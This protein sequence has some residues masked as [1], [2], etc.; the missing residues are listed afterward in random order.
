MWSDIL[1][2]RGYR[3]P[4]Q[5]RLFIQLV[6]NLFKERNIPLVKHM[7]MEFAL[8]LARAI[9]G[10]DLILKRDSFLL[11]VMS[12]PYPNYSPR[13]GSYKEQLNIPIRDF[14]IRNVNRET[15]S[16][17]EFMR[18]LYPLIERAADTLKES[19]DSKTILPE[20][21]SED[22]GMA[23]IKEFAE[24]IG[25]RFIPNRREMT[26]DAYPSRRGNRPTVESI[27]RKI[28]YFGGPPTLN[29][30]IVY[31]DINDVVFNMGFNN[32]GVSQLVLSKAKV[33]KL[34]R[35]THDTKI[36]EM[37]LG[38]D[39]PSEEIMDFIS[40]MA[41][42]DHFQSLE[43]V[44]AQS[45]SELLK[46]YVYTLN[47]INASNWTITRATP[48]GISA[49]TK[50]RQYVVTRIWDNYRRGIQTTVGYI[51]EYTATIV[52]ARM[53]TNRKFREL[54]ENTDTREEQELVVRRFFPGLFEPYFI[55]RRGRKAERVSI[56]YTPFADDGRYM[57]PQVGDRNFIAG[58]LRGTPSRIRNT[59]LSRSIAKKLDELG[60]RNTSGIIRAVKNAYATLYSVNYGDFN[61][62]E[63]PS[64]DILEEIFDYLQGNITLED[65]REEYNVP[66]EAADSIEDNKASFEFMTRGY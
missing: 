40:N 11:R 66:N 7:Y 12:Y 64:P 19:I 22:G 28:N 45:R 54:M 37:T 58:A 65:I 42:N 15:L 36:V 14:V 62:N 29:N 46:F 27:R 32:R 2:R 56:K 4:K 13:Y 38:T 1:K 48:D 17:E 33:G 55:P 52:D 9:Q 34:P 16:P 23:E 60:I 59:T 10:E 30:E 8:Q 49:D 35:T 57:P 39:N 51:M 31:T 5:P 26:T 24:S 50:P 3:A 20:G 47:H 53:R 25:A 6:D 44:N 43:S 63:S 41:R 18:K 21:L 61:E